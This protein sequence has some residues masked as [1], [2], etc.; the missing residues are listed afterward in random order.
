MY[1]TTYH[2]DI[3]VKLDNEEKTK[4]HVVRKIKLSKGEGEREEVYDYLA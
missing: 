3:C 2:G 4:D 1:I